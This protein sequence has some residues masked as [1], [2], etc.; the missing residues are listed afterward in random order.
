MLAIFPQNVN[1]CKRKPRSEPK[2]KIVL[3]KVNISVHLCLNPIFCLTFLVKY[4]FMFCNNCNAEKPR[5]DTNYGPAVLW[6][7]VCAKA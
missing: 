6:L 7:R 2:T 1:L 3:K 4:V 5:G